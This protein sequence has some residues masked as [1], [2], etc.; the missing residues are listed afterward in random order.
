[1]AQRG[2]A[3]ES[4]ARVLA[5]RGVG[6]ENAAA[7]LSPSLQAGPARPLDTDRHGCRGV[8]ARRRRRGAAKRSRSSATT[9]STARPPPHSSMTFLP[10]L[11]PSRASTSP[12]ASSRAT[13]RIRKRSTILIDGGATLIVCV[14]CGSTSFEALRARE[15]ARRRRRSCSTTIRS[16]R[17]S[18]RPSRSSIRTAATTFRGRAT[19]PPSA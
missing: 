8:A 6:L 1:M 9:T 13:G 18:R 19:S 7:Y 10:R 17:S 11:G 3:S 5:G 14:D 2:I 16:A 15:G 4:L 12:I